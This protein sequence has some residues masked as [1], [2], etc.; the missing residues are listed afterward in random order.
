MHGC[1]FA[2]FVEGVILAD[3][4]LL[5]GASASSVCTAMISLRTI[6]PTGMPVQPA[7]TSATAWLPTTGSTRWVFTLDRKS[8]SVSTLASSSR[9]FQF[10]VSGTSRSLEPAVLAAATWA[11]SLPC[12]FCTWAARSFSCSQR[13][14]SSSCVF[15]TS[16]L[17]SFK[18]FMRRSWSLPTMTSRSRIP[19]STSIPSSSR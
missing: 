3:D 19:I 1:A 4:S 15:K 2:E 12:S 9:V 6:L 13:F 10:F 7:T 8:R 5:L 14:F 18:S 16:A 11:S 17:R